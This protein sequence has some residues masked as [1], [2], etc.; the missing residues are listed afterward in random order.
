[1][2]AEDKLI[3]MLTMQGNLNA[4]VNPDW[5]KAGYPWHRAMMVEGVEALEH[6]GWKW[7]KR[8]EPDLVQARIELV[9]IWHFIMSM[10]LA[11]TSGDAAQAADNLLVRF[12]TTSRWTTL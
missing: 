5:L 2:I 10:T 11:S 1:M 7:W 8:Q 3:A 12:G 4:T 6:Y 9:D